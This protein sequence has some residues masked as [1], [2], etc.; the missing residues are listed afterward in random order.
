MLKKLTAITLILVLAA[1]CLCGCSNVKEGEGAQPAPAQTEQPGNGDE[2]AAPAAETKSPGEK[3]KIAF[4]VKSLQSAF[5][6]NM[7]EAAEQCGMDYADK[8]EVETMAPQTPF[9]IEEQIQLVEQCITNQVDAIVIAPCD[10]EGIVP[11]I[12]KANNAGI[13]VVTANT[14][15]NGGDI[16]SYVGAQNYD[17]GYSLAVALFEK[18]GGQGDVVLIEG[19]AGNSTSEE[20]TAGFKA[21]LEEYPG[22]TLLA[23]QPADWD[24]ASAMTVAENCLQ[25]YDKIDGMLTLTKDMGLGALE[26]IKSAGREDEIVSMTF[27]VD[28]DVNAALASGALYASGNQNEKSQAYIA[29][30]TA[31]FALDGYA[32]SNEQIMPISVVT[33]D[34]LD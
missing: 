4:I 15:A 11:A 27:D 19:K 23:S 17:V 18:L 3:Y 6:I 33:A 20:R 25:A 12:E 22:I 32:V 14:K 28:D 26:A 13:L 21:A 30:M 7:V 16:V 5:F 31:V 2:A 10:S 8:I 34:D 24:R 29:I 1:T 9:N